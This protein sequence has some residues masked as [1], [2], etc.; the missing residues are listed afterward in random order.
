LEENGRPFLKNGL[1][2][3]FSLEIGVFL[4]ISAPF[5]HLAQSLWKMTQYQKTEEFYQRLFRARPY[6]GGFAQVA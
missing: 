5:T 3:R 1:F 4:Q 2:F 6:P